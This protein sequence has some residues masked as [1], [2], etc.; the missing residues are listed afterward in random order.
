ML[1]NDYGKLMVYTTGMSSSR[2][3]ARSV[4]SAAEKAAELLNLDFEMISQNEG[5]NIYVYYEYDGGEPIPLYC[6]GG[7]AFDKQEIVAK[8]RNMMFVLSFH[9]KH[10]ALRRVRDSIMRLS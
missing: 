7:K 9:P 8:L 3:R 10:T 4:K 6:D 5:S 1:K 2:G